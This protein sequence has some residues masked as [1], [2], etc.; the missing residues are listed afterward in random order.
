MKVFV[1][2]DCVDSQG[3]F[4]KASSAPDID[5]EKE[6][7][8]FDLGLVVVYNKEVHGEA[9][10]DTAQALKAA[11]AKIAELEEVNSDLADANIKLEGFLKEAINLPKGQKPEGYEG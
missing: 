10:E 7:K 6:R 9:K 8:L 3:N 4:L 2:K 5:K 1:K 11:N